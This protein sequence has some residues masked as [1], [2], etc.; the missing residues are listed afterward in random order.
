[1]TKNGY[2]ANTSW[3]K[4]TARHLSVVAG[5]CNCDK[6]ETQK[7]SLAA[8]VSFHSDRHQVTTDHH[9]FCIGNVNIDSR[10]DSDLVLQVDTFGSAFIIISIS[11]M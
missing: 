11:I 5:Y 2:E 3:N 10:Y 1:M 7:R 6:S 8:T 9:L 4:M